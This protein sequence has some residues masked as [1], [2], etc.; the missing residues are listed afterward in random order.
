MA[1][2]FFQRLVLADWFW[3]QI[4]LRDFDDAKSLLFNERSLGET[5]DGRTRFCEVLQGSQFESR[6]ISVAQLLEFDEEIVRF[7]R[8]ISAHPGRHFEGRRPQLQYFQY[9]A[10]LWNA[11][12][13]EQLFR[14][15]A[16]LCADLNEQIEIFN[17][18]APSEML[19]LLKP[20][21]LDK[22]AFWSATGSGKTLL[23]HVHLLQYR[24][25]QKR[26]QA[27]GNGASGAIGAAILLTPSEALSAQHREELA[28]SGLSSAPFAARA[29]DLD[30]GYDVQTLEFSKLG[31]ENGDKR[32]AVENFQ[33]G[34]HLVLV[35][36]GHRG[37]GGARADEEARAWKSARD[38]IG[39]GGFCYEYSATFE[40]VVGDHKSVIN[41]EYA[42]CIALDYSYRRF[43]DDGYGKNF[44]VFNVETPKSA[45]TKG[46]ASGIV[47]GAH[48]ANQE[49]YLSGALLSFF[50]QQRAFSR[51]Q[52]GD[53]MREWGYQLPLWVFVGSS[54]TKE[55]GSKELSDIET[56]LEFFALFLSERARFAAHLGALLRRES[57]LFAGAGDPF[58]SLFE[59][60]DAELGGDGALAYDTICDS[61]FNASGGSLKMAAL[62]DAEGEIAL[63]VGDNPAWGVINVGKAGELIKKCALN[64]RLAACVG[65]AKAQGASLFGGLNRADSQVHVLIGARK[66]AAGWN[67][68]RVSTLG[69]MNVGQTEGAQIIQLFGR[70]VRLRGWKGSLRRSAWS[71]APVPPGLQNAARELE[72]LGVF[73][74]KSGYMKVFQEQLERAGIATGL[75]QTL[76][77]ETQLREPKPPLPTLILPPDRAFAKSGAKVELCAAKVRWSEDGKVVEKLL[78]TEGALAKADLYP[79]V[80]AHLGARTR[81]IEAEN[82]GGAGAQTQ[83][84]KAAQLDFLDYD[85]L[86]ADLRIYKAERGYAYLFIERAALRATLERDDWQEIKAPD[87]LWSGQSNWRRARALWQETALVLLKRRADLLWGRA[88]DDYEKDRHL[89]A[90]FDWENDASLTRQY[91]FSVPLGDEGWQKFI[92]E[93]NQK[94]AASKWG[95]FGRDSMNGL[96]VFDVAPHL[97]RPLLGGKS[98]SEVKVTPQPL[99]AEEEQFLVDLAAYQTQNPAWFA[100]KRVF[101]LRNKEKEGVG[102]YDKGGFFPDFLLWILED[103]GRRTLAFVDPKGLRNLSGQ[104]DRKVQLFAHLKTKVEPAVNAGKTPQEQVRLRAFL[105]SNTLWHQVGWAGNWSRADAEAHGIFHQ[106]DEPQTYLEKLL[107]A[108]LG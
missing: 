57:E 39:Q 102:F 87:A 28:L 15:R 25:A 44:R 17:A 65:A 99:N 2:K 89:L 27:A 95:E 3:P 4:G 104:N 22:L 8:Q 31:E 55:T 80:T 63:S 76:S 47:A 88:K 81:G 85:A 23:M 20:N 93:A 59:S 43:Y 38:R 79:K 90:P 98:G 56:I 37:L 46:K 101:V 75:T 72:T 24:A 50:A 74:L 30:L 105:V 5:A 16:A 97:F 66:F 32:V 34:R 83:N 40:Q 68:F 52:N 49:R 54:V 92:A 33:G 6:R 35:D 108:A 51:A 62:Q 18:R 21:E 91:L 96:H 60:L 70:G 67:S 19:P 86:F 45:D 107:D 11:I 61:L 71:D 9:L 48:D 42:R 13:L 94:L 64:P 29:G 53:A 77:I 58:A 100:D 12:Y 7:W 26:A 78:A 10:C 14:D 106:K 73:G 1:L 36:E 82:G 84:W 103:G 41:R 69:L